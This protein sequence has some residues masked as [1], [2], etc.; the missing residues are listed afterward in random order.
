MSVD[1][2]RNVLTERSGH[3]HSLSRCIS[4]GRTKR[5]LLRERCAVGMR[6]VVSVALSLAAVAFGL[7]VCTAVAAHTSNPVSFELAPYPNNLTAIPATCR[8]WNRA[9]PSSCSLG[10]R[11]PLAPAMVL[12][13]YGLPPL[14]SSMPICVWS[15]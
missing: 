6:S 2:S 11:S 1:E 4:L 15:L 14:I 9:I 3:G 10:C 12:A 5:S 13:P 7:I 8:P